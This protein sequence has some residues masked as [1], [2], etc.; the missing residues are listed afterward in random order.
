[1]AGHAERIEMRKGDNKLCLPNTQRSFTLPDQ[2]QH[3]SG[4]TASWRHGYLFRAG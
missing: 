2:P 1:M 3:P 4:A